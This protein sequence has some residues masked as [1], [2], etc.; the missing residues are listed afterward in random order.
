MGE[1]AQE[2]TSRGTRQEGGG[3]DNVAAWSQ[4]PPEGHTAGVHVDGAGRLLH[5]A[6]HPA[7]SV[8]LHLGRTMPTRAAGWRLE[9]DL[10]IGRV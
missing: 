9:R 2:E 10:V 8:H 1:E 3:Q 6:L 7:A 5:H 4:G